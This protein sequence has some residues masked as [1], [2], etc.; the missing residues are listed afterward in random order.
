MF[1][2]I[3]FFFLKRW[4]HAQ[5][6]C[7]PQCVLVQFSELAVVACKMMSINFISNQLVKSW[8]FAD[9]TH[10]PNHSQ[11]LNN[12]KQGAEYIALLQVNTINKKTVEKLLGTVPLGN[13]AVNFNNLSG[14]ASSGLASKTLCLACQVIII[15]FNA[16][17]KLFDSFQFP[18]VT[19]EA[20][21]CAQLQHLC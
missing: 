2:S 13:I 1:H 21:L 10:R 18:A 7:D 3:S 16:F 9:I 6:C 15:H 12:E 5:S 8:T 14:L 4:H 20:V 19:T 11:D 17:Y